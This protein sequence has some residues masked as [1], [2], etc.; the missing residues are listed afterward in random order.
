MVATIMSAMMNFG[1]KF[2]VMKYA[3]AN[4]FAIYN[5]GIL[6][7]TIVL[8]VYQSFNFIWF[9][10]FLREKDLVVLRRK[11]RRYIL[12]IF[13]GLSAI[14][15]CLWLG[16]FIALEWKIIPQKYNGVL[17]ILPIL[18]LSQVFAALVGLLANY[19]TY[20]EKTYIQIFVGA[21]I[22]MFGYFLCDYFVK[23]YLGIGAA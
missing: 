7:A 18:I 1:D 21:G 4:D 5:L 23:G 22:S 14:G 16:T 10:V 13:F 9:Q 19:M 17:T 20:F 2:F 15:L 11:T 6:L 8:I 12:I 3:G